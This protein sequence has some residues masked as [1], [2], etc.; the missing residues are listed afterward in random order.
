MNAVASNVSPEMSAAASAFVSQITGRYMHSVADSVAQAG[1]AQEV[2]AAVEDAAPVAMGQDAA[3]TADN[4]AASEVPESAT[5]PPALELE[6]PEEVQNDSLQAEGGDGV[7][8]SS[9]PT[10]SRSPH[11]DR[12]EAGS[13]LAGYLCGT[14][15]TV[16]GPSPGPSRASRHEVSTSQSYG[17]LAPTPSVAEA[18]T[19]TACEDRAASSAEVE[20]PASVPRPF[21]PSPPGT[22]PAGAARRPAPMVQ[23]RASQP[24][25]PVTRTA[26]AVLPEPCLQT[27]EDVEREAL[28]A[29]LAARQ[30]VSQT[31]LS[32]VLR[33]AA[34]AAA[35]LPQPP[36]AQASSVDSHPDSKAVTATEQDSKASGSLDQTLT[37]RDMDNGEGR[38]PSSTGQEKK[39][40]S[41]SAGENEKTEPSSAGQDNKSEAASPGDSKKIDSSSA[42]DAEKQKQ[43]SAADAQH[44]GVVS[45]TLVLPDLST[46]GRRTSS[47]RSSRLMSPRHSATSALD[48]L[49]PPSEQAQSSTASGA[50]TTP[51]TGRL[52]PQRSSFS[53]RL[54]NDA[55]SAKVGRRSSL[56]A[57]ASGNQDE[58]LKRRGSDCG[59]PR[60]RQQ[61][62][63]LTPG[64]A[65]KP[66]GGKPLPDAC[67][68]CGNVFK[69][70]ALFCR[71]CGAKRVPLEITKEPTHEMCSCGNA[72]KAD[73]VFCRKCGTKRPQAENA[74]HDV[75]SCGNL[76]KADSRFCRKCGLSRPGLERT[77]T[78]RSVAATRKPRPPGI[79]GPSGATSSPPVDE[80]EALELGSAWGGSGSD[81]DDVRSMRSCLSALGDVDDLDCGESPT[82]QTGT[83]E[84]GAEP[85]WVDPYNMSM[86]DWQ[87]ELDKPLSTEE[88]PV[89]NA[90]SLP[91]SA[92]QWPVAQSPWPQTGP[93][94][95]D[96]VLGSCAAVGWADP[97][98]VYS[99]ESGA[100]LEATVSGD[101][102]GQL[103]AK[104]CFDSMFGYAPVTL[105]LDEA[106]ASTM[107]AAVGGVPMMPVSWQPD[108]QQQWQQQQWQQ[109]LWQQQLWQQQYMPGYMPGLTSQSPESDYPMSG[110][111]EDYEDAEMAPQNSEPSQDDASRPLQASEYFRKSF[112]ETS[113]AEKDLIIVS[114]RGG[115]GGASA[116]ASVKDEA[117]AGSTPG[118]SRPSIL[119]HMMDESGG[120]ELAGGLASPS[121]TGDAATGLQVRS[122][123]LLQQL[124]KTRDGPKRSMTPAAGV[125]RGGASYD[126]GARTRP[127]SVAGVLGTS[128]GGRRRGA[129]HPSNVG[130]GPPSLPAW[131]T[132]FSNVHERRIPKYDALIDDQ[133]PV[134]TSPARLKHLIKTRELSSEYF[135]IIRQRFESH[136][137]NFDPDRKLGDRLRPSP[138]GVRDHRGKVPA[139]M[140]QR[141]EE[142]HGQQGMDAPWEDWE[143]AG[144]NADDSEA[145]GATLLA[146]AW[147]PQVAP[148]LAC[149]TEWHDTPLHYSCIREREGS[150]DMLPF[151]GDGV[152]EAV[153]E[154]EGGPASERL[155][156]R[157]ERLRARVE[158]LWRELSIP[159][160]I[161]EAMQRGPFTSVTAD[162]VYRLEMHQQELLEYRAA[163]RS[164]ILDCMEREVLSKAVQQAHVL[165]V[166]D[167]RLAMLRDNLTALDQIGT[168]LVRAIGT[169]SRRFGHL[170]VDVS[171]VPS[172]AAGG[173]RP[174]AVFQWIGRDVVEWI[175]TEA[176]AI[177]SGHPWGDSAQPATKETSREAPRRSQIGGRGEPS[178]K[179]ASSPLVSLAMSGQRFKVGDVLHEGPPPTWY[180]PRVA[181]AG[182]QAIRRGIPCG[183][184]EK[185][186]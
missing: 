55:A 132:S 53:S 94:A 8:V 61:R 69:A 42:G 24:A 48:T 50:P 28:C 140:L 158:M 134:M 100:A 27:A 82:M 13:A 1:T 59:V 70:D 9:T 156:T 22:A 137:R 176:E 186:R 121:P 181:K 77:A 63:T 166:N 36:P 120:G 127:S 15:S 79:S 20:V 163:T 118:R 2:V 110:S 155:P 45:Q 125:H 115:V 143:L 57:V 167:K 148:T 86:S 119:G 165:G 144:A 16:P 31:V 17:A 74:C 68:S 18:P 30:F 154:P 153:A 146:S 80:N 97:S 99:A 87:Q 10:D 95:S 182:I 93:Q 183:G 160:D 83:T 105:S 26:P 60:I 131:D 179:M 185:R 39:N 109:Q 14:P 133:C 32:T 152:A 75:C 71:K 139:S 46:E 174:R 49:S 150:G 41:S 101:Q 67:T 56:T 98:S 136:R 92:T 123:R 149:S 43:S 124:E 104:P 5:C 38:E 58:E 106:T 29:K 96:A 172:I 37:S 171:K 117:T 44:E 4:V 173:V 12:S 52:R 62:S 129:G 33:K 102:L 169:W 34:L 112:R 130:N 51:S 175:Q 116:Q 78:R 177:A 85:L 164:I 113:N 122:V 142:L 180:H 90:A 91:Q 89:W 88:E 25:A 114:T 76:F 81:E 65:M 157:W 40:E 73:A 23:R 84:Q 54:G 103:L 161:R 126:M 19:P 108:P 145:A 7:H 35:E 162:S 11:K 159:V 64:L 128:K 66:K 141:V 6:A 168:C 178:L 151:L 47:K 184:G 135:H 3:A 72:F 111:N 107:Y 170:A 21:L 138:P 147:K